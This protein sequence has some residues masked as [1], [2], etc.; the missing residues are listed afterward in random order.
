MYFIFLCPIPTPP[1][2]PVAALIQYKDMV[3]IPYD[4]KFNKS[5]NSSHSTQK[6]IH[7]YAYIYIY[8]VILCNQN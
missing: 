2:I 5:Y 3:M 7:S 6:K 4:R 8:I 1:L